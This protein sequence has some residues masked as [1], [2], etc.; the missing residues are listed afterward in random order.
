[1]KIR[2]PFL[3]SA[4][5]VNTNH[6][7]NLMEQT[8][9]SRRYKWQQPCLV[10]VSLPTGMKRPANGEQTPYVVCFAGFGHEPTIGMLSANN[11]PITAC[12]L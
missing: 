12:Y 9:V 5:V 8:A 2:V 10:I 6:P 3:K 11:Y 1:V 4:K 7:P